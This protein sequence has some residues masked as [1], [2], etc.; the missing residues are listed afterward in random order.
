MCLTLMAIAAQGQLLSW[1]P[2]FIRESGTANIEITADA[3]RGNRGLENY[4]TPSDVYVHIGL[5]T[6]LSNSPTDWKYVRFSSFNTPNAAAQCV[7]LG[8]NRWRYTIT[9]GLRA[10]FGVTNASERILRIAILFRSGNGSVVLRNTD[11][12]DM[13]VPVY[14]DG[15]AVRIDQPFRQPL[16]TPKPEVLNLKVGD[17]LP[18]SM[19]AGPASTLKLF[20]NGTQLGA[21]VPNASSISSNST[22]SSSGSQIIVAEASSGGV[23]VRD[24]VSFFVAS[25]TPEGPVPAGLRNGINYEPGD[26]SV[27]L[28]LFAPGKTDV[29]VLGD[30]NDWTESARY[31]MT[32]SSD[33]RFWL[34]ITGLTPGTEYGY[35]FL[36]DGTL[37]VA[38]YYTEKVLDPWNDPFIG[39]SRYPGLKAYPTGKATGIVSVLQTA[40]P[41]YNWKVQNFSRPD[42]RNLVIYELHLRDFLAQSD[43]RTLT[44][45]L[46]YLKRLTYGK[47]IVNRL[48]KQLCSGV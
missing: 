34:R 47:H 40:K 11:G 19:K 42:K 39:S 36:V 31:Q 15:L 27:T 43:W 21:T 25:P 2:D 9:G 16:Y 41:R 8:S 13:Y 5:I 32:R 28:V 29:M 4:S 46:P 22:V 3:T 45:T 23:T 48:E 37:R 6:S 38:D 20:Y 24:T 10:F 44:D 14:D 1:T 35:Q 18:I 33:G 30:F 7:S 26:T 12:T 17:N